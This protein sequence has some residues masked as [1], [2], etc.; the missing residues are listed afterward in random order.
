LEAKLQELRLRFKEERRSRLEIEAVV[1]ERDEYYRLLLESAPIAIAI[2]DNKKFLFSNRAHRKI[3]GASD[4]AELIGL[5]VLNVIDKEYRELFLQRQRAVLEE[6]TNMPLTTFRCRRLDGSMIEVETVALP[7]IYGGKKVIMGLARDVTRQKCA[8]KEVR[9]QRDQ[10]IQADKLASL[11]IVASG[12]AH[13][14][15]NPNNFIMMNASLLGRIWNDLLPVLDTVYS[16]RGEFMLGRMTYTQVREK[17]K[18]LCSGIM[19]GSKRIEHTVKELKDF[20]RP[21]ESGIDIMLDLNDVIL[22]AI[23]L[24]SNLIRKS[25]RHFSFDPTKGIPHVRGNFQKLEQVMVNLIVN[26]CQALEDDSKAVEISIVHDRALGRVVVSVRDEGEGIPLENLPRI[27]DPFFTT[28]RSSGGTGLGLSVSS[29]IIVDHGA[30]LEYH[31]EP[32]EGTVA[33]LGFPV[34]Q[35]EGNSS[36]DLLH[37][38]SRKS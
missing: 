26:A 19:E 13:E 25:T 16:D 7:F 21:E 30:T 23:H 37:K 6:G 1:K 4:P 5:N 29:R 8:E 35:N 32:G 17:V 18:S 9:R 24:L 11:G 15:S 38:E 36:T 28:K 27:K 31:S 14:I 33:I 10:L 3:M 12:V 20:A 22:T 2:Y 34:P